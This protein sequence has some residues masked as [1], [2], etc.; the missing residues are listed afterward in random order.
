MPELPEV[1][2]VARGVARNVM[3]LRIDKVFLVYGHLIYGHPAPLCAALAGR[4]IEEVCRRGK[5][6][7]IELEESWRLIVH[8]GMTGRLVVVD[9][10]ISLHKH[11][12]LR[13]TFRRRRAELRFID[14]RRFGRLW[15]T[16]PGMGEVDGWIG[17]KPPPVAAD[18]LEVGYQDFRV[19][20]Q[21]NRQIKA[22]LLDQQPLSGIGNI[23]CDE[24]LHRAGIHPG[25]LA[26]RLDADQSRALWQALRRVLREAIRAGGST[27][28]DYRQADGKLG[29]FQS[30]HRVYG[31][32]GK[33]CKICGTTIERLVVAGRGT[34]ICPQCQAFAARGKRE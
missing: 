30:K 27:I 20:L 32:A 8:L 15:L 18:P 29:V 13:I 34:F 6:V 24:S 5:Q 3:G 33:P 11:T 2:T 25:T 4:R 28:S 19:L 17:R 26:N 7:H 31:R 22:L 16:G 14:P 1:E 23:Y 21:R 9:R 10:D 12:H